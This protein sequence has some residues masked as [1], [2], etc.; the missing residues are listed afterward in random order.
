MLATKPIILPRTT[1]TA[2]AVAHLREE[3]IAGRL[4]PGAALPEARVGELLGV[5]RAPV[6]E[7]LTLL[8]SEGLVEFDRRGTARVCTFGTDDIRE[9]GLL[10]LALE[11][12]AARL[13]CENWNASAC[14]ALEQN[15][16]ELR[17]AKT[18][19]EVTRLDVEFHRLILKFAGNCR[20]L[21]AWERFASQF[22]LVMSRF[23]RALHERARGVRETTH[24][25]HAELFEGL[26]RGNP[27]RA[28]SLAREHATD[29]FNEFRAEGNP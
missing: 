6:R 8:E 18:L 13:T 17:Q 23:H 9:L 25:C 28:E 3:I 15:L 5:S 27:V 19:V 29:W 1:V 24:R 16:R 2:S 21:E 22:L 20:L 4:E 11:P 14:A 26:K 7:A 10:R 12:I